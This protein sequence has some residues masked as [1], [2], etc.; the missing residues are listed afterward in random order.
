MTEATRT[1][2]LYAR[3]STRVQ[4]EEGSSSHQQIETLLGW[5]EDEDHEVPVGQLGIEPRRPGRSPDDA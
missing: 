4:S 5:L 2:I 3:V 1:A